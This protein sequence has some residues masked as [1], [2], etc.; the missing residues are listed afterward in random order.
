MPRFGWSSSC[1]LVAVSQIVS[2]VVVVVGCMVSFFTNS[3]V[4]KEEK[5]KLINN[6]PKNNYGSYGSDYITV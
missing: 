5:E 2:M 6:N 4:D 1:V 3:K